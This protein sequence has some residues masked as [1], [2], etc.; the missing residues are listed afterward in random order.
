[1]EQPRPTAASLVADLRARKGA[2]MSR[3][4]RKTPTAVP[5]T[6]RYEISGM[7]PEGTL[8]NIAT[9][10]P[11]TP[12]FEDAFA[13]FARG[14][15]I[16]TTEGPIAVE[17]LVP[18]MMLVT[19]DHREE[20]LMWI[21]SM[22]I[23]P[24]IQG[25]SEESVRLVRATAD[26]FGLGRPM[27]DLVLGPRAR[28]FFKHSKCIDMFGTDAAVAPAH[29][30][31]DGESMISVN[32]VTP[33]RVYHLAVHGQRILLANGLEVES[34]HPGNKVEDLMDP[35]T[36]EMF[37]GLFPHIHSLNEFGPMKYPR[38]TAF[39]LENIRFG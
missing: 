27:P 21:G 35:D 24:G 39:E 14:T 25:I 23:F 8:T 18:G 15:L 13:G 17:D 11:A 9:V 29:G 5:F 28:V 7:T 34:Y 16:H 12:V 20:P 22:M 1:M 31:T 26:S 10:A 19:A 3:P 2:P 37:L 36:L 33:I 4:V 6:R 30:F 32:P 38:V